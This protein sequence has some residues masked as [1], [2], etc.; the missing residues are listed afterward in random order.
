[1]NESC[2]VPW[3]ESQIASLNGYQQ[4]GYHHPFTCGEREP[5]GSHHVL[6][7][8]RDGWYCPICAAAGKPYAQ[9]WCHEFMADWSWKRSRE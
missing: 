5:D 6:R 3:D 4:C 1:M 9:D 8:T 2:K 7:A